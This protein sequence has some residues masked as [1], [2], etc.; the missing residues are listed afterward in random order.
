MSNTLSQKS[1]KYTRSKKLQNQR[2]VCKP[3]TTMESRWKC[4]GFSRERARVSGNKSPN[5]TLT[6]VLITHERC[7]INLFHTNQCKFHF[8]PLTKLRTVLSIS[9]KKKIIKKLYEFLSVRNMRIIY[10]SLCQSIFQYVLLFWGGLNQNAVR[11]LQL[12]RKKKII[13]ICL[14]KSILIGSTKI[15][16][17]LLD[18]VPF[19]CTQ[20][21]LGISYII[22]NFEFFMDM[23]N[24][25]S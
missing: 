18:L 16:S 10:L 1:Q 3:I 22:K 21:K 25:N 6:I 4:R 14:S 11:P 20:K 23:E 2:Y 13:K 9:K 15:Y 7:I 12:L 17:K 19:E 5:V 24:K 8:Y